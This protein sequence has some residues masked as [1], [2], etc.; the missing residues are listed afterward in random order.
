MI[1]VSS[2]FEAPNSFSSVKLC[3]LGEGICLKILLFQSLQKEY[4]FVVGAV[5]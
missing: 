3:R 5:I 4:C 1:A 2:F